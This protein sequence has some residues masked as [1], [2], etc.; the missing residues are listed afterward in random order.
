[1][2]SISL[3]I[4]IASANSSFISNQDG[5][6]SF[7]NINDTSAIENT[8][9]DT[10]FMDIPSGEGS[11]LNL[12]QNPN[13][14]AGAGIDQVASRKAG[15]TLLARGKAYP[16]SRHATNAGNYAFNGYMYFIFSSEY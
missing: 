7:V 1:M 12:D 16:L 15:R 11:L 10:R 2:I 9:D 3:S 4:Y 6:R 14:V 13:Q 8:D 5:N